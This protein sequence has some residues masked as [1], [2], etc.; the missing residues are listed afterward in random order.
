MVTPI[1]NASGLKTFS[2]KELFL[3][4]LDDLNSLLVRKDL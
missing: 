3:P 1:T 4:T 2:L